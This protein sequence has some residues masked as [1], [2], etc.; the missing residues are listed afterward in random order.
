MCDG[1]LSAQAWLD[2]TGDLLL[3]APSRVASHQLIY[4]AIWNV[5]SGVTAGR[6]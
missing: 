4:R 5:D 2:Q 1:P 3:A 6:D